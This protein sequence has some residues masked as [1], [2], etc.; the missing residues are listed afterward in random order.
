VGLAEPFAPPRRR[1]CADVIGL[2]DR[3]SGLPS[4]PVDA[5]RAS[6]RRA[7]ARISDSIFVSDSD[8][9]SDSGAVSETIASRDAKQLRWRFVKRFTDGI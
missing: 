2:I 3:P 9:D 4:L 8:S 5:S 7:T 1:E 6:E